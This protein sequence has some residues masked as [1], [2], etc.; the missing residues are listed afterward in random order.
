MW[1]FRVARKEWKKI[2]DW[3]HCWCLFS[4]AEW[5]GKMCSKVRNAVE[6][7][8]LLFAFH[9]LET[10][11]KMIHRKPVRSTSVD[12]GR[13]H[14][15]AVVVALRQREFRPIQSREKTLFIIDFCL[16]KFSDDI[17]CCCLRINIYTTLRLRQFLFFRKRENWDIKTASDTKASNLH[18]CI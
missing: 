3:C 4:D 2:F 9:T 12:R 18:E 7:R 14:L 11:S 1:G 16:W 5:D 15:C 13:I 10:S 6:C 8:R 17:R